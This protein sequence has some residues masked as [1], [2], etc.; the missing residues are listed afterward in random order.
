MSVLISIMKKN[1]HEESLTASN[2]EY[3]FP[4]DALIV[5]LFRFELGQWVF[6]GTATRCN[7]IAICQLEQIYSASALCAFPLGFLSDQVW[8]LLHKLE[9]KQ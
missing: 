2:F 4:F 3:A 1:N 7:A 8:Y 5:A 9:A 6:A